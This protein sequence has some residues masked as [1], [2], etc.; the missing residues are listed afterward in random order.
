MFGE[1]FKHSLVIFF[2]KPCLTVPFHQPFPELI[3][4]IDKYE[5]CTVEQLYG[6]FTLYME[7]TALM[8]T[9]S[10]FFFHW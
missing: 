10:D 1:V 8:M 9:G 7:N 2:I 6:D 3:T 4:R 5:W